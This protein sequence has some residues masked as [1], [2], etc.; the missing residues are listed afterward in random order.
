MEA[1]DQVM[2]S[3]VSGS[4]GGGS[5]DGMGLSR[6]SA[7]NNR[8]FDDKSKS[9]SLDNLLDAPGGNI[10][11]RYNIQFRLNIYCNTKRLKMNT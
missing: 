6:T 8:Y 5:G 11:V 3:A 4:T 9:R 2:G 10:Q 1:H 7:L